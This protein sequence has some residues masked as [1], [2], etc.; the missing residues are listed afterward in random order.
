MKIHEFQAK[1]HLKKYK[2]PVPDGA[3]AFLAPLVETMKIGHVRR[4]RKI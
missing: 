2:V 1:E 4:G 3:A